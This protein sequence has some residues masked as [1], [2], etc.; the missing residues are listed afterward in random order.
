MMTKKFRRGKAEEFNAKTQR[1]GV[2]KETANHA[3]HANGIAAI[4]SKTLNR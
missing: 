3:N 2:A 1:C 4:E